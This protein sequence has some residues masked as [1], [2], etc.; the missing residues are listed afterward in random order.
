MLKKIISGW[1]AAPGAPEGWD[2]KIH[3]GEC[4]T[5]PIRVF[6]ESNGTIFCESAWEPTPDEV[7]LLLSG[8]QIVLRVY[9]WQPAVA[10][11]VEPMKPEDPL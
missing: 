9:G 8:G 5:L 3:G 6:Q 10:L 1:N 7:A 2:P 11:Y 4:H